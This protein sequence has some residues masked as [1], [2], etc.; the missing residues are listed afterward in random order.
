MGD[1]YDQVTDILGTG[2]HF[3]QQAGRETDGTGLS[4]ASCWEVG[5]VWEETLHVTPPIPRKLGEP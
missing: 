4:I 2:Y 5:K 3:A 1:G